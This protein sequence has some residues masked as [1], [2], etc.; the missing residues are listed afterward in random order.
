MVTPRTA[1]G[2]TPRLQRHTRPPSAA[3]GSV[4]SSP[5]V[6][7]HAVAQLSPS[8]PARRRVSPADDLSVFTAHLPATFDPT[9]ATRPEWAAYAAWVVS[10]VVFR[11]FT[12]K[13]ADEETFVPLAHRYVNRHIPKKVRR[14]LLD[15][16]VRAGVLEC[17]DVYYFNHRPG[18]R[19]GRP[20]RGGTGKCRC[21][22][23]GAAHRG[24]AIRPHPVAHPELLRKVNAERRRER[25]ALA[26]PVHLALRAWHD[27]VEVLPAAPAGEHPLLDAMIAGERRFTVCDQ[28][29]VHTNV[30]NVP[31]QYRQYL[32]LDGQELVACDIATSQP[33]LLGILLRR[34]GACG[35]PHTH[36]HPRPHPQA[37][38]APCSDAGLTDYLRDC[39]DGSLYDRL[40]SETGYARD[41][42]KSLFLAVVYGDPRDM[43]TV[44]GE[45]VR[46][47]YPVVFAAVTDLAYELG[48]G[49]L[50]REMQRLES[51]VMIGRVARRVVRE[52]PELPVL[53]VHDSIVVPAGAVAYVRGIIADEWQAAFGVVPRV[54]ISEFTAP[55]LPREKAPRRRCDG[56]AQQRRATK[57][58]ADSSAGCPLPTA[59]SPA[60]FRG[61]GGDEHRRPPPRPA[62]GHPPRV[63]VPPGHQGRPTHPVPLP[64]V[65]VRVVPAETR[66]EGSGDPPA[67]LPAPAAALLRHPE[68]DRRRAHLGREDGRLPPDLRPE[69]E[70]LPEARRQHRIRPADRVRHPRAAARPPVPDLVAG[71]VAGRDEGGGQ[72]V[73]DGRLPRP[74]DRGLS[75]PGEE[76]RRDGE[77]RRQ[78]PQGPA[79][80]AAAA[81]R[82]GRREVPDEPQVEGVPGEG[83]G[84]AVGRPDQGV[85]PAA[86]DAR[87]TAGA[88]SGD[89]PDP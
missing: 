35:H 52:R 65:C 79:G 51:G 3:A 74:E 49:G 82:L 53:T 60:C 78:E 46:R 38:Y 59:G 44:V 28:G 21:Y 45:A 27:R 14:P 36:I 9:R 50:A 86:R 72:G 8:R 47:L 19:S 89:G 84:G 33:L 43:H 83:Q 4:G 75:G 1:R 41:D 10:A 11:R 76:R 67:V 26:D 23:L 54:K 24:A 63:Q 64:A 66:R 57:R 2:A 81:G 18:R 17:D 25:A 80:R 70:G 40:A 13:D 87:P 85:V 15:D 16:L 6:P 48:H 30:A 77:L 22:R 55:Q 34:P 61:V 12:D 71:G 58:E 31:R 42:V 88:A 62:A 20:T 5:A 56:G 68:A 37:L 32:R 73:L 39:L 69:A 29:R 7:A